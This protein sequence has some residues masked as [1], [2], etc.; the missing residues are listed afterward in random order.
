MI[1]LNTEHHAFAVYL[2]VI[3]LAIYTSRSVAL[4]VAS[5][6]VNFHQA[7]FVANIIYSIFLIPSG[8]LINLDDIW[9]GLAWVSDISYL[10]FSFESLAVNEFT[11]LTFTCSM[12]PLPEI[13]IEYPSNPPPLSP[14]LSLSR[15]GRLHQRPDSGGKGARFLYSNGRSRPEVLLPRRHVGEGEHSLPIRC[16]CLFPDFLLHF[17]PFYQSATGVSARRCA[18]LSNSFFSTK[19]K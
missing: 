19:K 3:F 9:K 11:G 1:Q 14:S 10:K 13:F 17:P 16:D 4:C 5:L 15:W 12:S 8:F 18:C 7:S 2:W 6:I